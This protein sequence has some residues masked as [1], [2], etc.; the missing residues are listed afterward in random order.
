VTDTTST[1]P[2]PAAA[3]S[4]GLPARILG[5]VFAPRD[6]YA[7]VAARPRALG[8]LLFVIFVVGL[9]SFVFL[10]SEVGQNAML[11]QQIR[12]MESFG[13]EIPD[14]AYDQLEASAGRARYFAL[15]GVLFTVP[16]VSAAVAGLILLIFNVALGGDATFKQAYALVAHSQILIALQQLFVTPLNYARESMSSATNLAIFF[17]ML[18]EAGFAARLLG[19]IDLFRIWWIVSLSIGIGVLYR[20]KTAPI[21]WSLLAVYAVIALAIA[22]VGTVLAGA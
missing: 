14:E 4:K 13:I 20:R 2:G 16:I 21:A 10:S 18:D 6:T 3:A 7:E 8:A 1:L 17:P 22:V 5:V 9:S 19:W 12:T 11:D 15:G